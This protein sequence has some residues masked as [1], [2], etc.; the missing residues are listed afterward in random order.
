M[1]GGAVALVVAAA[2]AVLAAAAPASARTH[3]L[4]KPGTNASFCTP[5]LST[6]AFSPTG[7]GMFTT[8]DGEPTSWEDALRR[9]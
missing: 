2:A 4:C 5:G 8:R 1:R 6:T 9:S 3:W 7:W